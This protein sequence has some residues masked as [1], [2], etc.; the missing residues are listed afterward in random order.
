LLSSYPSHTEHKYGDLAKDA[1]WG[2]RLKYLIKKYGWYALGVYSVVGIVNFGVTFAAVSWLGAE[3]VAGAAAAIKSAMYREAVE[4][5]EQTAARAE[6]AERD[7]MYATAVIALML[8]KTLL[9]PLRVGVTAAFTPKLVGF[10]RA[11]GWAGP[12][13]TLQASREM[14]QK[15]QD[16]RE[17]KKGH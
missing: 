6:E 3:R 16:M 5:V 4:D 12:R 17:R 2:Q 14:R 11:R 10:L 7:G 15:A 13:G 9:L 1:T 8:H